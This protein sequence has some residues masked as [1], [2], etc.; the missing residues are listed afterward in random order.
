MLNE[1]LV[2]LGKLVDAQGLAGPDAAKFVTWDGEGVP[3]VTDG[4][5]S[6]FK[7]LLAGWRVVDVETE[8]RAVG[9]L[10]TREIAAAFLRRARRVRPRRTTRHEPAGAQLRRKFLPAVRCCVS[11]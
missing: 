7:E 4:P 5:Y 11:T 2:A 6:E 1:E 10:T 8:E 3:V 9:G